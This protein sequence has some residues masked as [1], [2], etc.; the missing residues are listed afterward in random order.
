MGSL[1]DTPLRQFASD[2]F[3]GICPEAWAAMEEANTG[4]AAAY[5]G[6][7]WTEEATRLIREVFE[8]DCEVFFVWNGTS[9]NSLAVAA[10]CAPYESVL[11]HEHAHLATD[12]CGAPGFFAHGVSIVPLHGARGKF[13]FAELEC[14]ARKRTDVHHPKP[15]LVSV[16]QSTE[17]GTVYSA[18]EVAAIGSTVDDLRLRLHMDGARLANAVAGLGVAPRAITWEA[19]VDVLTLGGTKNGM[20]CG[21][22]LIFFDK[23]LAREFA[24]RRKQSGQL[25]SKMRFLA[26]PW[27]GMLR[28]GAWLRHASQANAM[29]AQLE[30]G[31]RALP[32]VTISYPR[33][34]NAV[35]AMLPDPMVERLSKHGWHFYT[36]VGP[37]GA[38]RLM[39]SWDTTSDDVSAFLRDAADLAN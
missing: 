18:N 13:G 22:A 20:A 32:G 23:H 1:P 3:A 24:F 29:A 38:A 28:D 15:R 21:E 6:D 36:D 39:C 5:G 35:F 30:Q 25:A 7:C 12:E 16:T 2:N 9:A 17:L 19:G 31:L 14:A 34:A 10:A 37:D 11:C 27:V 26:A 8:T 4:H 33:Q